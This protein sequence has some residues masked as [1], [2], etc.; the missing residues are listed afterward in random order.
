MTTAPEALSTTDDQAH[1]R[2]RHIGTRPGAGLLMTDDALDYASAAEAVDEAGLGEDFHSV[3]PMLLVPVPTFTHRTQVAEVEP[4]FWASPLMWL[5]ESL[6][7]GADNLSD[8]QA[9]RIGWELVRAGLYDPTE[10]FLDMPFTVGVDV[11][12]P[13]GAARIRAW[14]EGNADAQLDSIDLTAWL[15]RPEGH[16]DNWSL[17]LAQETLSSARA[18]V[19]ASSSQSLLAH[20]SAIREE[21]SDDAEQFTQGVSTVL[22]LSIFLLSGIEYQQ[23]DTAEY[24]EDLWKRLD[25]PAVSTVGIVQREVVKPLEEMLDFIHQHTFQ[26]LVGF[27]QLLSELFGDDQ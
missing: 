16:D 13:E 14:A 17:Q 8:L 3:S 12:T 6:R 2:R 1:I 21:L 22:G 19:W 25:D 15:H 27:E 7:P 24:L 20:L 10:G 18:S 4:R 26:A 23:R 5:P 9:L 11:E